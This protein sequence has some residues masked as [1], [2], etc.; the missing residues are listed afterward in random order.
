MSE[1]AFCPFGPDHELLVFP[2]YF[3]DDS[4]VHPAVECL[5]CGAT[6]PDGDTVEEAIALWNRRLLPSPEAIAPHQPKI[7]TPGSA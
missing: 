7:W 1:L 2:G 4:V 6:G 3:T 5:T